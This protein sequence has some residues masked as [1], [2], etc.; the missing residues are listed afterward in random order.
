MKIIFIQ[1]NSKLHVVNKDNLKESMQNFSQ[2]LCD[3]LN[4]LHNY[5]NDQANDQV[6]N[7]KFLGFTQGVLS[8]IHH[9]E[10]TKDAI[11]S[12]L[13]KLKHIITLDCINHKMISIKDNK[14]LTEN[15]ELLVKISNDV[16]SFEHKSKKI[17]C[18]F[19]IWISEQLSE[20]MK[21]AFRENENEQHKF[22]TENG[23]QREKN[24]YTIKDTF[25]RLC[26]DCISMI[27]K[28]MELAQQKNEPAK[29]SK[30]HNTYLNKMF[31]NIIQGNVKLQDPLHNLTLHTI[32]YMKNAKIYP[33]EKIIQTKKEINKPKPHPIL[34]LFKNI[35]EL[36]D[37]A[38][39]I[40][41]PKKKKTKQETIPSIFSP[42]KEKKD[43]GGENLL[44]PI[45]KK[46]LNPDNTKQNSNK[47]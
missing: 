13:E 12:M 20:F 38:N 42:K 6:N 43:D 15:D 8:S 25:K 44:E 39:K 32:S 19:I 35:K 14:T 46:L 23:F 28:I 17:E 30:I 45:S 3:T 2:K 9:I 33:E 27:K 31:N 5:F 41:T 7:L 1:K 36:C 11:L 37:M 18:P 29:I 24:T 16:I 22:L 21:L 40:F 47:I 34:L 4:G 26:K 10:D